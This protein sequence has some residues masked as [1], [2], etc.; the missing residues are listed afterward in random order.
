MVLHPIMAGI[1]HA[2]PQYFVHRTPSEDFILEHMF[3]LEYVVSGKGYIELN[4]QKYTVEAGDF[5]LLNRNT[6]P[7]YYADPHEPYEKIWV[8][9]SGLFM[10]AL[11][12]TYRINDPILIVHCEE[13]ELYLRRLHDTIRRHLPD[14]LE[15]GYEEM[16]HILLD[17]FQHIDRLR[18]SET[19][20][21]NT[22]NFNQL[23]DCI[24]NRLVGVHVDPK[25]LCDYFYIS[26]STLF[27]LCMKNVGLSPNQ[28]ILK[29]K[30]DYA[31]SVFL[32]RKM[33]VS[34]VAE[35]LQFSSPGYFCKVF[36]KYTGKSLT[37]WKQEKNL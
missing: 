23:T 19:I 11:T 15:D 21:R 5:Y 35:M 14:G 30:I 7:Y 9:V 24:N 3:V 1:T 27:R 4:N 29:L 22:V 34:Q 26:Y 32:S 6:F 8:N 17:L 12:Y 36:K 31:Q 33:S 2:D 10:N 20:I 18:K 37:E 16:M 25:Y 13:A 28:Y